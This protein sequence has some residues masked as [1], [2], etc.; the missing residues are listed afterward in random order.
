M[1]NKRENKTFFSAFSPEILDSAASCGITCGTRLNNSLM[2]Y[3]VCTCMYVFLIIRTTCICK[4]YSSDKRKKKSNNTSNWFIKNLT[5][6]YTITWY[7]TILDTSTSRLPVV[8]CFVLAFFFLFPDL[9]SNCDRSNDYGNFW[10]E[11]S[12][13]YVLL[14]KT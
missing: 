14:V 5:V 13:A 12:Y 4:Y 11:G 9:T 3:C 6:H 7:H 10:S 1:R 8:W 2:K